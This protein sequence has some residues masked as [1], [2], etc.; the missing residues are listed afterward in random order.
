VRSQLSADQTRESRFASRY[1][2]FCAGFGFS[3][4]YGFTAIY[5][6]LYS[7]YGFMTATCNLLVTFGDVHWAEL[8]RPQRCAGV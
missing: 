8:I 5:L 6:R 7:R 4:D 2:C 3:A 1:Q